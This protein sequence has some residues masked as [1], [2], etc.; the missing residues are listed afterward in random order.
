MVQ[1]KK[2]EL[3][4][5]AEDG[6]FPFLSEHLLKT[7]FNPQDEVIRNHLVLGIAVKD[8]CVVPSYK[9]KERKNPKR[10]RLSTEEDKTPTPQQNSSNLPGT[11]P[12][13]YTFDSET[14][15]KQTRLLSGYRTFALPT[16]DLVDDAAALFLKNC[17][18][19]N[20]EKQNTEEVVSPK[21]LS[22][23]STNDKLSLNTPNGM[24]HITPAL[25]VQVV[26]KLQCPSMLVLHDQTH[27]E[28]RKKRKNSCKERS[29]DWLNIC[30]N[31]LGELE[32]RKLA[33]WAPLPCFDSE[34]SLKDSLEFLSKKQDQFEGIFIPGWHHIK[35]EEDRIKL[36][37]ECK[38]AFKSETKFGISSAST[39]DQILEAAKSGISTI[40]TAAPMGWAREFKAVAWSDLDSSESI[41]SKSS[42]LLDKNGC[43]D[44]SD[45]VYFRDASPILEGCNCLACKDNTFTRSYIHHLIKA[46][47]LLAEILIF[48]HNLHQI[49]R[50][51]QKLS[52]ESA[53]E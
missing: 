15:E 34:V 9:P 51:F 39:L 14:I 20:G 11:K 37:K 13:G 45:E 3:L 36:T 31:T 29:K 32:K 41:F 46:K 24:Q 23:S 50:L 25:Y 52:D 38:Q 28:E 18:K 8:T 12:N 10:K 26:H 35:T 22:A 17:R 2:L 43:M 16:F 42:K 5:H 4:L 1:G 49:L 7:Y 47:E 44:M 48:A 33:V 30:L 21:A 40:G 19:K 53:L 6:S 27:P